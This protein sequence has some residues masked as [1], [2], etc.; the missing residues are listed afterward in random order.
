MLKGVR[1]TV[2]L[3][4]RACRPAVKSLQAPL[5]IRAGE[6]VTGQIRLRCAVA[7][8]VSVELSTST[9][10]LTG[11]RRVRVAAGHAGA[12]FP[13]SA[14]LLRAD[15]HS[16]NVTARVGSTHAARQVLVTPGI[17]EANFVNDDGGLTLG[18]LLTGR[19]P[20][21]GATLSLHSD[22]AALSV[23]NSYFLPPTGS[24]LGRISDIETHDVEVDTRV[25]LTLTLGLRTFRLST[26]LFAPDGR[27]AIWASVMPLDIDEEPHVLYGGAQDRD[28]NAGVSS[29]AREGDTATMSLSGDTWALE[30]WYPDDYMDDLGY[31]ST[32]FH[33][34]DVVRTSYVVAHVYHGT[35]AIAVPLTIHPMVIAVE[36][37]ETTVGGSPFPV[38]L[39]LAGPADDDI[40]VR[41][42]PSWGIVQ[43]IDPV[44]IPAG[45]TSVTFEGF[46]AEVDA[47]SDVRLH[48]GV[49]ANH[50]MSNT[51]TVL[52]APTQAERLGRHSS[53]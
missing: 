38:T 44:T 23:P 41:L 8:G 28:L 24:R 26:V 20:D 14:P 7:E 25:T 48:A 42:Q 17:A 10:S 46:V 27:P 37:P 1:K 16:A 32:R 3:T 13:M 30:E 49:G 36:L 34:A 53:W 15:Q 39:R 19:L 45:Q 47:P 12:I 43:D 4:T 52:P 9:P 18:L 33:V 22:N 11:P 51:M 31:T 40:L 2:S 50:L 5:Q 35:H 6:R 29:A 21:E